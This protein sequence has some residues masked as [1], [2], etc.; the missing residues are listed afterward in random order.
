MFANG[1]RERLVQARQ[2]K[3]CIGGSTSRERERERERGRCVCVCVFFLNFVS[4]FFFYSGNSSTYFKVLCRSLQKK[5]S[6]RA[7][8]L[9]V[10][11]LEYNLG[12]EI[13][14]SKVGLQ[15]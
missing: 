10:S 15:Y 3:P 6:D 8:C 9:A 1:E 2:S 7:R 4:L 12:P 11:I 5:K 14:G 13:N